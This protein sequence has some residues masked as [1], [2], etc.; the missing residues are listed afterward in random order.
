[1]SVIGIVDFGRTVIGLAWVRG[2]LDA[3][4][5]QSVANMMSVDGFRRTITH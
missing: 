4:L 3:D 1:M 2:A 5:D